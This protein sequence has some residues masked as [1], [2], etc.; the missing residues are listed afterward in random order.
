[1]F[2]FLLTLIAPFLASLL[3]HAAPYQAYSGPP[4]ALTE[5]AQFSCKGDRG[6]TPLT[7]LY[8]VDG[9]TR[10]EFTGG[11]L[12]FGFNKT[13]AIGAFALA[14]LPGEHTFEIVLNNRRGPAAKGATEI[15]VKRIRVQMEAGRRYRFSHEGFAI[16]VAFDGDN[17]SSTAP[18][19]TVDDAPAYREPA[20]TTAFATLEYQ[21]AKRD[22][23]HP[24]LLRVD[25]SVTTAPGAIPEV[26]YSLPVFKSYSGAK[27]ALSLRLAPGPHTLEFMLL[28]GRVL[29]GLVQV[30][31]ITVEAGKTYAL[32]IEKTEL[33]GSTI[34][35]AKLRLVAR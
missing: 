23:I 14:L 25:D 10:T 18:V 13:H 15:V 33:K 3:A 26:N 30:E 34:T 19:Y 6:I 24:Y 8:K 28:G 29:D 17:A 16:A 5:T 31:T 27:G 11:L 35:S 1:M 9:R 21:A 2:R 7:W 12:P 22:E 20:A 4:R 32:E